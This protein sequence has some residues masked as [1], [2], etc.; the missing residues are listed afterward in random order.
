MTDKTLVSESR[1]SV[2]RPLT[3]K[4]PSARSRVREGIRRLILT[5][6]LPPGTRLGQQNLAERFKVAQT[7]VRESLLELQLTGLVQ[8]V[9]NVGVF[10]SSLNHAQ[11][12]EAYEVRE[13]LEGVAAARCCQHASRSDIHALRELAEQSYQAG[14]DGDSA[15]RGAYDREFHHRIIRIARNSVLIRLTDAFHT[16]GMMVTAARPHDFIRAEHLAIVAAIERNN[17]PEAERLAR[18]H[19]AG[20]RRAIEEEMATGDFKPRWVME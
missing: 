19:V 6:E 11:L 20:V 1:T 3:G 8:S 14:V 12:L 2:I 15:A 16:L 13:A 9:D 5:G 7:V 18:Q 10:V 17:P 4:E